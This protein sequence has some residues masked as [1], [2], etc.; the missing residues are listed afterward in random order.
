MHSLEPADSESLDSTH[1]AS[2]VVNKTP[3]DATEGQEPIKDQE[4]YDRVKKRKFAVI[5][6]GAKSF[7]CYVVDSIELDED[8]N[9][10]WSSEEEK[11][12][13]KS[14]YVVA[15]KDLPA[16][17]KSGL[18]DDLAVDLESTHFEP[19]NEY[20]WSQP[21]TLPDRE[22]IKDTCEREKHRFKTVF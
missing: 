6:Y 8:L 5:D 10:V 14:K 16:L 18:L 11:K 17:F 15:A 4:F 2:F 20:S 3:V 9:V 13:W 12:A 21:L 7:T 22:M 19:K 1:S